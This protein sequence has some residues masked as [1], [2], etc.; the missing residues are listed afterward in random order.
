M[1][2]HLP[3]TMLMTEDNNQYFRRAYVDRMGNDYDYL[4]QC[5][6]CNASIVIEK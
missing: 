2:V 5:S 3:V 1:C 4:T 6:K